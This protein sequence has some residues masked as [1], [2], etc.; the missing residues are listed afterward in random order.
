MPPTFV[1]EHEVPLEVEVNHRH[2][3]RPQQ[4]TCSHGEFS[5]NWPRIS[6]PLP[7]QTSVSVWPKIC[8]SNWH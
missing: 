3:H 7:V 4:T 1:S 8:K 6:V 5:Q 2:L